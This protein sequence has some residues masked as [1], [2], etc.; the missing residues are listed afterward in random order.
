MIREHTFL[1]LVIGVTLSL[2]LHAALV[3]WAPPIGLQV[4]LPRLPS[5]VEVQLREWPVVSSTTP[6]QEPT[7]I[8]E[9]PP[10]PPV[11]PTPPKPTVPP[12]TVALQEAVQA[13]G[14]PVQA[15]R[16][17][18]PAPEL[19]R[20]MRELAMPPD[21]LQMAQALR[22]AFPPKLQPTDATVRL[23][24][25]GPERIVPDRQDSP[26]LPALERYQRPETA[27]TRP[28]T[29]PIVGSSP[30]LQ[31]Q[32]PAA[33]RQVIFQPPPPAAT[34]DREIDIELRFWILPNGTVS[35]VVPLKKAD[36]RL[37]ALAISYLRQWRFSPLRTDV[38]A[39]EQWGIIPFKFRI[40]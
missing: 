6:P 35:R 5:E 39:D 3:M 13:L 26:P 30:A 28:V 21:R 36:P 23:P 31:I 10:E 2:L 4:T 32:G 19:P 20:T 14:T 38:A 37:E 16:V 25:P 8:V 22:D 40:R 1:N 17:D 34:V 27:L 12:D 24:P 7:R 29:T 33:E 15:D 18:T 11:I 9:A